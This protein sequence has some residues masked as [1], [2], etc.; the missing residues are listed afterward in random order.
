MQL[1]C[2]F[3]VFFFLWCLVTFFR[4]VSKPLE[5]R[6][7]NHIV[8]IFFIEDYT[9]SVRLLAPLTH[10]MFEIAFHIH[11][12][13]MLIY[14]WLKL[15]YLVNCSVC[16]NKYTMLFI[17][18]T[19]FSPIQVFTSVNCKLPIDVFMCIGFSPIHVFT[20]VN[21]MLPIDVFMCIQVLIANYCK[22]VNLRLSCLDCL[23]GTKL[24]SVLPTLERSYNIMEPIS[25]FNK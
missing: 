1:A 10:K 6:N 3:S 17:F 23:Y 16:M 20:S 18:C 9:F 22:E 19:G 11:I 8:E 25:D 24:R 21:R 12:L 14:P 7:H 15:V 13:L 4:L 2:L 5:P